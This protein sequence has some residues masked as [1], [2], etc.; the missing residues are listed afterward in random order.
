MHSPFSHDNLRYNESAITGQDDI[1]PN[2]RQGRAHVFD[3]GL[4]R[5]TPLTAQQP[6]FEYLNT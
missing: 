4:G 3:S 5:D 2:P 6:I 1:P